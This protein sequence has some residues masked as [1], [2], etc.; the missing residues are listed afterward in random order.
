MK[1]WLS[2]I[3][4]II[5]LSVSACK[6]G[7][8]N[9][10]VLTGYDFVSPDASVILPDILHEISGLTHIDSTLFACIQD[11]KG[12]LFFYDLA[13]NEISNRMEFFIKGDYEGITRVK[14]T[15]YV[16]RSDGTLF[17]IPDYKSG[18]AIATPYPTEIPS[19]DNEGLCYDSKNNRLLIACKD[20]PGKGDLLKDDRY[21][22]TFDLRSKSLDKEPAF[23]FDVAMLK[24]YAA[25]HHID[26]PLKERKKGS[27]L[28]PVLKFRASAIGIHPLTGKLYLISAEDY[29]LF[30]FDMNGNIEQMIKL[31]PGLYLQPEGIAFFDNGDMV[32]SNEGQSKV[33]A[34][35][36]RLNYHPEKI[37]P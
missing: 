12:I 7:K 4:V 1:Y 5:M 9:N 20:N 27:S 37:H 30:I 34:T 23:S 3:S 13:K 35:L 33:P 18:D 31:N 10:V 26:L 17:E 16:L 15:I 8:V 21:I 2:I 32:I 28:E 14:D 22:F 19:K 24:E 6:T 36:R 11:E 29:L 25:K